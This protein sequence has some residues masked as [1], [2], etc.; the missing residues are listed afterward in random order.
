[1]GGTASPLGWCMAYDPVVEGLATATGAGGPTY[2]DDLAGRTEGAEQTIRAAFYMVFASWA[3]GLEVSTHRCHRLRFAG[4]SCPPQGGVRATAGLR[5]ACRRR[6]GGLGT[7]PRADQG[8][9]GRGNRREGWSARGDSRSMQ[10]LAQGGAGACPGTWVLEGSDGPHPLRWI[11]GE[12]L[13]A[14]PRGGC[15]LAAAGCWYWRGSVG[16]AGS[17]GGGGR[18]QRPAARQ[19]RRHDPCHGRPW[20]AARGV[21]RTTGGA[22]GQ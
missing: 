2:V 10:M 7:A 6:G 20:A 16:H 8:L 17:G 13:L 15:H 11:G 18:L 9:R 19:R 1:M 12:G 5:G 3:A 21:P 14:L 22:G 4:D